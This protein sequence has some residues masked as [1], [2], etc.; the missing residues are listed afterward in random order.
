MLVRVLGGIEVRPASDRAW[1]RPPAQQ[2]VVLALL[3]TDLGRSCGIDRVVDAVW[4]DD[5]PDRAGRLV[6]ALVSRLRTLLDP[7]GDPGSRV[8]RAAGGW[9]LALDR[10][11]VD[12]AR[13][14]D[15]AHTA[16]SLLADGRRDDARRVLAQAVGVWRGRPFGELADHP[17]LAG[18]TIRLEELWLAVR[19]QQLELALRAGE[20]AAVVASL[21]EMVVAH[22]L[23]ERL[24]ALL[25]EALYGS[26][27]QADALAAYQRLRDRLVAELGTEPGPEVQRLHRAVLRHELPV[28][29]ADRPES[30]AT[31]PAASVRT[32]GTA[33][34]TRPSAA[35]VSW[36]C[37]RDLPLVGRGEQ[38]AALRQALAAVGRGQRK[39]VLVSGEPGAGKTR[40]VADLADES[41]AAGAAVLVGRCVDGAEVPYQPFLEAL[42]LDLDR[43]SAGQHASR[44]HERLGA[45]VGELARL[46]PR[47][48]AWTGVQQPPPSDSPELDQ[49]RLFEAVAAWLAT[50]ADDDGPLLLV[51][52]DLHAATRPT[53]QLLRH[54]VR[55]GPSARFM[56][57]GTYRDTAEELSEELVDT[58]AAV[59]R[60][61]EVTHIALS[62]L[63]AQSVGQLVAHS[64]DTDEAKREHMTAELHAAT[65]GNALFVQELLAGLRSN[66]ATDAA[67][68]VDGELPWSLRQLFDSRFR[69]LSP[70]ALRLLEQAAVAGETFDFAVVARASGVSEDAA[71][72][73]LDEV[74]RARLATPDAPVPDR[75]TF[76]HAL[77]RSALLGRVTPSR[78]MRLHAH[79]AAAIEQRYAAVPDAVSSEL[80]YHFYEAGPVGDPGKALRY[81]VAAAE[82]ATVQLAYD[83]AATHYQRALD[84][85]DAASSAGPDTERRR[86][87]LLIALGD[88]QQRAGPGV[89][90]ET[91]R[92]ALEVAIQLGDADRAARAAWANNRGF[93]RHLFHVDEDRVV[94]LERAVSS[95][96]EDTPGPRAILLAVLG[97]ELT[98]GSDLARPRRLSDEAVGLARNADEAV[99][100]RVLTLRQFTIQNPATVPERLTDTQE[101]VALADRLG[102]PKLRI[103]ARWWRATVALQAGARPE[104]DARIDEACRLADELG[105]PFLRAGS[106]MMAANRT[107]AWGH[108][109]ELPVLAERYR[110]LGWQADAVDIDGPYCGHLL[111]L[112]REQGDLATALPTLEKLYDKYWH[113]PHVPAAMAPAWWEAGRRQE[114]VDVLERFAR[115]GFDKIPLTMIWSHILCPLAEVAAA[116]GH[117]EAAAAL[118]AH[119]AP[120]A[121]QVSAEQAICEGAIAHYLGLLATAT[122]DWPAAEDYLEQAARMHDRLGAVRWGNRTR[123]AQARL[124]LARGRPG[125]LDAVEELLDSTAVAARKEGQF[126]VVHA[127]D[128]LRSGRDP[129]GH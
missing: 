71:L 15:L 19:E 112:H 12:S 31:V 34:P 17:F 95:A 87:D 27:R 7:P 54:L 85:L 67:G 10:E 106:L 70:E 1:V 88:A 86:C 28:A 102:E 118:R 3:V 37:R 45:Q 98:F 91:L 48:A 60:H 23:R 108:L 2:R 56:L 55:S 120:Y 128:A 11:E 68:T 14:E 100:A 125:D 127:C 104:A 66:A 82:T 114:A 41:A 72:T 73:A 65:A 8:Q 24:W 13:F 101:L 93:P 74:T 113:L 38:F 16:S 89:H 121:D 21:Q 32:D 122:K 84:R 109:D 126:A 50:T 129:G 115:D 69:R 44:L 4:G 33:A 43:S 105:E 124:W 77:V 76:T 119:L 5:P 97:G 107:L 26:G 117:T 81:A 22:P 62:G 59:A 47:L 36:P 64:I 6:Q 94:L 111:W 30:A 39:A 78:W 90:S 49:F 79:L 40:L 57:I 92:R 58:L 35:P 46:D 53:L 20:H 110:E 51:L 83:E 29:Q 61:P 63:D 42:R 25:I 80:S 52:E 99:L 18:E 116:C 123:L 75:Y 103:F 96:P 9:R